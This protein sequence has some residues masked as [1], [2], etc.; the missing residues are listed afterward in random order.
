MF[1]MLAEVSFRFV[2]RPLRA[3]IGRQRIR[4][5]NETMIPSGPRT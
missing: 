5:D 2:E 3:R 4:S 1:V